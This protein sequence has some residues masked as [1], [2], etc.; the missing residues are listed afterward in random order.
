M[1][2]AFALPARSAPAPASRPI[3]IFRIRVPPCLNTALP[4]SKRRTRFG[5]GAGALRP[6]FHQEARRGADRGVILDV[7]LG[8]R[9]RLGG[10]HAAIGTLAHMEAQRNDK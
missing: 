8:R 3:A 6:E 2:D 5:S 9:P 10:N 1:S 7:I 4:A